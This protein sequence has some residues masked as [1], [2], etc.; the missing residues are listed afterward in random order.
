[1]KL[2]RRVE[3]GKQIYKSCHGRDTRCT[4]LNIRLDQVAKTSRYHTVGKLIPL[5]AK[6]FVP[7]RVQNIWGKVKISSVR[8]PK[9]SMV[10]TAGQAKTKLIR[11]NPK[12][13]HRAV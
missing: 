2:T 11:P 8:L 1:M 13:A 3:R 12:L 10:Q 4:V 7:R 6:P 5:H 9:V